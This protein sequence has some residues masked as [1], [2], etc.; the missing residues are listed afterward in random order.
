MIHSSCK[1]GAGPYGLNGTRCAAAESRQDTAMDAEVV[2]VTSKIG[3]FAGR[4]VS[5]K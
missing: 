3:L 5:Q 2:T 1:D 4:P